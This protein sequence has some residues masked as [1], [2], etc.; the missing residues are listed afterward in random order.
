MKNLLIIILI[1]VFFL[2]CVYSYPYLG[3]RDSS[4]GNTKRN[5]IITNI[6]KESVCGYKEVDI[7]SNRYE[8]LTTCIPRTVPKCCNPPLGEPMCI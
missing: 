4:T 7:F 5:N 3:N 1:K 8:E 6:K 2:G